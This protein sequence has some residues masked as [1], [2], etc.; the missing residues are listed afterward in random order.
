MSSI[1]LSPV[2]LQ[3]MRKAVAAGKKK[4][5]VGSKAIAKSALALECLSGVGSEAMSSRNSPQLPVSK[6]KADELSSS[7]GLSEPSSHY[8]AQRNL[9]GEGPAAQSS[10]GEL[11][12]ESSRQPRMTKGGLA[13]TAVLARCTGPQ[14][15]SGLH[16]PAA[17]G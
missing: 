6:R 13:Y 12:A 7:D 9:F 4:T 1:K 5:L 2:F 16:K 8:P 3:E 11:P 15:P 17:T 10:M 14:Q